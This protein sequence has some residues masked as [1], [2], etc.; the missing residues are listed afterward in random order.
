MKKILTFLAILLMSFCLSAFTMKS[1][2]LTLILNVEGVTSVAFTQEDIT[3][4]SSFGIDT[5]YQLQTVKE[6]DI[7]NFYGSLATTENIGL[8]IGF[9]LPNVMTCTDTDDTIEVTYLT[10][11]GD[12]VAGNPYE[13]EYILAESRTI[14]EASIPLSLQI[15]D[16]SE[17]TQGEYSAYIT[18][19]V[20]ANT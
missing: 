1:A 18:M 11:P 6:G 10:Y 2:S 3:S 16:S 7:L 13:R 5:T 12:E 15:G 4:D 9:I 8:K 19:M 20:T 17:A 14:R